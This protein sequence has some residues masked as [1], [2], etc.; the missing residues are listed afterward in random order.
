MDVRADRDADPYVGRRAFRAGDQRFFCGRDHESRRLAEVWRGNRLTILHGPAGIG[1]TSVVQ[2]GAAPSLAADG[3]VVLPVAQAL[4]ASSFPEPLLAGR[5]PFT[6]AV[7]RC[8]APAEPRARLARQSI[9]SFL[10]GYARPGCRVFVSVDQVEE[11]VV[12]ASPDVREFFAD[13]AAAARELSGLRL[14]LVARDDSVDMLAPYEKLFPRDVA[15]LGLPALTAAAAVSAV[16]T[17]LERSGRAVAAGA[18]EALVSGISGSR[19]TEIHPAH[20]Q[21]ECAA[22]W[23]LIA[24]ERVSLTPEFLRYT[25]DVTRVMAEYCADIAVEASERYLVGRDRIFGWLLRCADA[26]DGL[27]GSDLPDNVLRMLENW[28]IVTAKPAFSGTVYTLV[29]DVVTT[30]V[31]SLG[32][33]KET[34]SG[35]SADFTA[36]R[37]FAESALARGEFALAQAHSERALYDADPG[38]LRVQADIWSFL[39]NIAFRSGDLPA[40]ER[41]YR[42]AAGLYE[43]VGDHAGVGRLFGAI[44]C[45]YVRLGRY[46]E[47]LE[48]L[49]VA[50]TRLPSDPQLQTQMA[51]AL[52]RSG[53]TQA[54]SA[55]FGAVLCVEPESADALAGRGQI[56]AEWGNAEAALDDLRALHRIL[57]GADQLPEVRSAYALALACQG[58]QETAMA[59]AD[60]AVAAARDSAVIFLR[61]ARV[62]RA[63]GAFQRAAELLRLA[64][65]ATHPALSSEQR[66]QVDRLLAKVSAAQAP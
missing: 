56:R 52:W 12:S 49:Q 64:E 19:E 66:G 63:G 11:V 14:L 24:S 16:R 48:D 43:Q 53:Q 32:L 7:L 30:A 41:H 8:W 42:H 31:R 50:V 18:A 35:R 20:L 36:R 17:P 1:K 38:D 58:Q 25:F 45:I 2:A 23:Q 54:A 26:S 10:R 55:L 60:A 57:P 33:L 37:E 3:E 21:A 51:T 29:N 6:V 9:T 61:A 5:N 4:A 62:A 15:R 13:L 59:E 47:A 46:L 65:S 34:Y 22:L 27:P 40:A 28:Y 44:G 39:G